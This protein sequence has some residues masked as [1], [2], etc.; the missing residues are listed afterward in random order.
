MSHELDVAC[1]F[2]DAAAAR[3]QQATLGGQRGEG[4]CL[5]LAEALLALTAEDAFDRRSGA[6]LYQAIGVDIAAVEH[7]AEVSSERRFTGTQEADEEDMVASTFT[8]AI[9]ERPHSL[10][11]AGKITQGTP[12]EDTEDL[13]VP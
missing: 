1:C 13:R 10:I 6:T 4:R 9:R 3:D 7:T 8:G 12:L 11:L 5:Q 2:Y